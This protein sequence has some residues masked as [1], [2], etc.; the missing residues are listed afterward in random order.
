MELNV[1]KRELLFFLLLLE[2]L[3]CLITL[4]LACVCV[5]VCVSVVVKAAAGKPSINAFSLSMTIAPIYLIGTI[6]E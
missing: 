6:E 4:K 1:H 3:M 2:V 5:R